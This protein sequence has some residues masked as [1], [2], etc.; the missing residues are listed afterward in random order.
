MGS[1]TDARVQSLRASRA[2]VNRSTVIA[3]SLQALVALPLA[4]A[5]LSAR[6]TELQYRAQN[7][8]LEEGRSLVGKARYEQALEELTLAENLPGNTNRHVA[9]IGALKATALLGMG[10]TP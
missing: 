3:L 2:I 9:E 1:S 10:A 8:N 4:L 7:L 5:P 6:A